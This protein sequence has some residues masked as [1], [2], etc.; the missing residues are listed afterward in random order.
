[1]STTISRRAFLKGSLAAGG[2]T[3]AVSVTPFGYSLLNAAEKGKALDSV[4]PNVWLL[5]TSDNKVTIYIG[6]S[7]MGQGVLTAQ[8]MIIAD[9]LE[10]DWKQVQIRQ[11]GAMDGFKSPILGAQ[12]TV[13]S[14]SLRGFYEP[15]RKAG[16]AGKAMLVK[17]AA[18]TWGVPESECKAELGKVVHGKSKK[19]LTYGQLCEKAAKLPVPKDP[20]LKNENEFRYMGKPMPR[21]DVPEKVRGKAIYGLDVNVKGMLHAVIARP[22]AYGAKPASFDQEAAEKVKGVVKVLKIPQGI[23]VCATSTEAALKGKDA[24]KVQWDKGSHPDMDTQSIEKLM[25]ADLDK[26][27]AKALDQ[28]D[29]KKA[30][31][32]ASKKV[33]AT[34]YVPMVA[35]ATMEPMNC[36]ADVRPD[37]CDIWAPTQGQTVAQMTAAKIADL[38]PDK[39]YINTTFLGCGL[40]RRARPDFVA[41]AVIISKALGKPVKV[42][43]TR[44]DD[45]LYD[46]FRA[47]IA[48]R[49]KGGLDAQG[50]LSGLSA[51]VASIPINKANPAAIKDGVDWYNLWGLWDVPNSPHWNNRIQYEI[52]SLYIEF[53]MTDLPMP[54]APWRSVTNAPNAFVNE[55]FMD[56]LAQ[57]A[58]KD[59]LEFRLQ[60]LKN[61][62]RA[63]RVLE[64]VAKMSG[65]GKPAP[66]GQG[67]GIAQ[68]ACFGT[69]VAEVV[70]LSVD[71]KTGEIKVHK[72]YVAVD[73]GPVINPGPLVEQIE[74]AVI[75]GLS[76]ALKEEVQFAK[77]GA[78][79]L[80]FED[81]QILRMSE[82]PDIEVQ[83]VKST[84]KIG[85]IGEP[86][87]PPL[88][89][90]VANAFFNATGVRVRR[91]PLTPKF[92]QEAL[93]KA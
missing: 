32:E 80:N 59:P 75:M 12:V 3:I 36:T 39:V 25:L 24:L 49:V 21:V 93:K 69:W 84:D 38:P 73:C 66:K 44:E 77:G 53:V 61:N 42:M 60:A 48:A 33:E 88:A 46:A 17:A 6:N 87:V 89:P 65:W 90:A 37:R 81:Y 54:T 16:A 28:G 58:G 47:P 74:S 40:G 13:G 20:T 92:V 5:I 9:E 82:V 68:H 31:E 78:S 50:R 70:D 79:S 26:P 41:E 91:I 51:K 8:S 57:A 72:V 7:E 30:L 29:A 83:V 85:G 19:S 67:R 23:A 10:A 43:W 45:I 71:K 64:T 22:P 86:G 15:L 35:H 27:G 14:G 62:K 1:M 11:G 55:C 34:Y 4:S 76:T 56:E 52:P 63:T 2:L 18:E